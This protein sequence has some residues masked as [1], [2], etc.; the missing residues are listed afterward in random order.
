V[1]SEQSS[2]MSQQHSPG[3]T[4]PLTLERGPDRAYEAYSEA[5]FGHFL[6]I[7][8]RRAERSGR[9][10]FLLLVDMKGD[11][12]N[13]RRCLADSVVH[14][15]FSAMM[16]SVREVDF[17]GWYRTGRIAGAVLTQGSEGPTPE[18]GQLIA[19]RVWKVLMRRLPA[20]VGAAVQ[21]RVLQLRSN[22]KS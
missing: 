18:V 10:L 11:G 12:T 8:R 4:S 9:S 3:L 15:M 13:E 19:K 5:A 20:R 16:A 21:V 2:T 22:V 14:R 7:E 17:V 1:D 6:A